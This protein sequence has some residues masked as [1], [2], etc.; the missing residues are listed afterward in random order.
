MADLKTP[1][2]V[3]LKMVQ[4]SN[5]TIQQRHFIINLWYASLPCSWHACPSSYSYLNNWFL[6][7]E[8]QSCK[9]YAYQQVQEQ[10]FNWACS[11]HDGGKCMFYELGNMKT[12]QNVNQ[13]MSPLIRKKDD[14]EWLV[15]YWNIPIKKCSVLIKE[16]FATHLVRYAVW[17]GPW[18]KRYLSNFEQKSWTTFGYHVVFNLTENWGYL[19]NMFI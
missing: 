7:L 17:H 1:T 19:K 10:F 11:M 5:P 8:S 14:S 15:G 12:L 3:H 2:Q 6:N 9:I 13:E 16:V 18:Q 4:T